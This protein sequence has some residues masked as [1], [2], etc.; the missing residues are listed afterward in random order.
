MT[1]KFS[2][3]TFAKKE[4]DNIN[5][6]FQVVC[7]LF[8]MMPVNEKLVLS[9]YVNFVRVIMIIATKDDMCAVGCSTVPIKILNFITIPRR[10]LFLNQSSLWRYFVAFRITCFVL[11]YS[12]SETFFLDLYSYQLLWRP[13]YFAVVWAWHL[14]WFRATV[15]PSAAPSRCIDSSV[16]NNPCE[17]YIY[18]FKV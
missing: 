1:V 7:K 12:A 13:A 2:L 18:S 11:S 14:E 9:K 4:K 5:G 6:V 16:D 8:L 15:R 3:G 17:T 10:P